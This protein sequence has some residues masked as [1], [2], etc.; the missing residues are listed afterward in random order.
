MNQAHLH[1]WLNHLPVIGS[2]FGLLILIGGIALKIPVVR[3]T[4]LAVLIFSALCAIPAYFTGEGAEEVVENLPGVADSF[5]ETHEDFASVYVWLMASL[6]IISSL[7]LFLDY[8]KTKSASFAY[9]LALMLGVVSVGASAWLGVTGGEIRHTEIRKDAV[10]S[11]QGN[12][13]EPQKE[14]EED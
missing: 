7:T 2:V 8:K 12:G 1:L 13:L 4:A 10:S 9:L 11:N 6:G 5:I 3:Q 14:E